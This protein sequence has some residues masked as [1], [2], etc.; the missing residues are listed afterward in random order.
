MWVAEPADT[1]AHKWFAYADYW[2]T[3][4]SASED[5][6][7]TVIWPGFPLPFMG[8]M[9]CLKYDAAASIDPPNGLPGLSGSSR[10]WHWCRWSTECGDVKQLKLI[11]MTAAA[12]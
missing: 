11:G 7:F 8:L 3:M 10:P 5:D 4:L 9:E 2:E 6:V 12:E 1:F